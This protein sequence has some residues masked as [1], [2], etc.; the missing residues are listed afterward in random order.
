MN[1]T[2]GNEAMPTV[3]R[4]GPQQALNPT[5]AKNEN[6]NHPRER[7]RKE[8]EPHMIWDLISDT[9]VTVPYLV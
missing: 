3:P 8:R 6:C 1:R 7:R 4:G 5:I 2:M 9:S